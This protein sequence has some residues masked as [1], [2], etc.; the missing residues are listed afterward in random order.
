[1]VFWRKRSIGSFQRLWC[2]LAPSGEGFNS[3]EIG[4]GR[5]HATRVHDGDEGAE[6]FNIPRFIIGVRYH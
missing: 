2:G 6:E 5:N 3:G 4:R 1:M